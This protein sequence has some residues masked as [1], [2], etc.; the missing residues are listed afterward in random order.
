MTRSIARA[1]LLLSL[2]LMTG[3]RWYEMQKTAVMRAA[4]DTMLASIVKLQSGT[5][6]TQSKTRVAPAPAPA[7]SA[8]QLCHLHRQKG[9]TATMIVVRCRERMRM[10]SR[11]A[12]KNVRRVI[13]IADDQGV[14]RQI[15]VEYDAAS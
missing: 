6:L 13:V 7:P 14:P 15:R 2:L 12:G 8:P 9:R 3:C 10:L 11:V 4:S 1:A 5:P